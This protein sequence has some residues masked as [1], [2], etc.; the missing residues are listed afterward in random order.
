MRRIKKLTVLFIAFY[1]PLQSSAWGVLG[2]RIVGAVAD[3]YL[4][5]EAKKEIKALL[6]NESIAMASN[7]MDFIKSDTTFKYLSNWHYVNI[8]GGLNRKDVREADRRGYEHQRIYED[9]VCC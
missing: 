8:A 2:H 3:T 7:W 4:S 6:G 1:L 9:Q 5:E